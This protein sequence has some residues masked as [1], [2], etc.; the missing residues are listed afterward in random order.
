MLDELHGLLYDSV[1]I[2]REEIFGAEVGS[3]WVEMRDKGQAK[4]AMQ[5]LKGRVYDGREVKMCFV[6]E[7]VYH[8]WIK[9]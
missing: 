4:K 6:E 5:R 7:N 3:I 9:G 2:S 8:K 1:F